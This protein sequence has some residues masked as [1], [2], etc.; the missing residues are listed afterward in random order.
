M[1]ED[2]TI[3]MHKIMDEVS[4]EAEEALKKGIAT[5]SRETASKLKSS[6]PRRTGKYAS[7]WTVRQEKDGAVV[8]NRTKPRL[9]HLLEN[10]HVIRN[11]KGTYGRVSGRKHIKPAEEWAAAELPKEIMRNME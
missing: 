6:S 8:Y 9:T 11:A 4:K 2:I 1:A 10:G 7:G 3:Q 5:V